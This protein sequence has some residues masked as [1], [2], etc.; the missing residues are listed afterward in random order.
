L[1]RFWLPFGEPKIQMVP[2]KIGVEV[3]L[4]LHAIFVMIWSPPSRPQRR[5]RSPKTP[6]RVPQE[7]PRGSKRLP[8]P[9]QEA[10]KHLEMVLRAVPKHSIPPTSPKSMNP[11][12]L[13][14]SCRMKE[15]GGRRWSPLGKSIRRPPPEPAEGRSRA[16]QTHRLKPYPHAKSPLAGLNMPYK[17]A[18]PKKVCF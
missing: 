13:A 4:F 5:P 3:D 6:P 1:D 2:P 16:C 17:Y 11:K 14:T 10:A 12:G 9:P 15:A 8:R 18:N 7:V